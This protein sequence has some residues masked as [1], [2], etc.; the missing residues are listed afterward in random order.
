MRNMRKQAERFGTE[1]GTG[2]VNAVDL[3]QRPFK[4]NVEGADELSAETLILSTGASAKYMGIPNE[5][6]NLVR[7]LPRQSAAVWRPSIA[8]GTSKPLGMYNNNNKREERY[9]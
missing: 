8:K 7:P 4:L 1:F 6:E 5:K 9:A 3:S 2:W